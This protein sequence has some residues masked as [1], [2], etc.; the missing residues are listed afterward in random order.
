[1]LASSPTQ[2]LFAL[3]ALWTRVSATE[4]AFSRLCP[5]GTVRDLVRW[6]NGWSVAYLSRKFQRAKLVTVRLLQSRIW[7]V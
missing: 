5:L 6:P 3:S 1:M 2:S 7:P 4:C